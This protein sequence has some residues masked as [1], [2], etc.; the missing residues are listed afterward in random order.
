[1]AFVYTYICPQLMINREHEF[2][3]EKVKVKSGKGFMGGFRCRKGK[4]KIMFLY[5]ILN[6]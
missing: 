6:K 2:E 5:Y 4:G 3:S 1:M